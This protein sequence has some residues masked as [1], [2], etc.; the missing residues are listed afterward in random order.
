MPKLRSPHQGSFAPSA[1]RQFRRFKRQNAEAVLRFGVQ[2]MYLVQNPQSV[3]SVQRHRRL[4]FKRYL[5]LI[6]CGGVAAGR[7]NL[8]WFAWVFSAEPLHFAGCAPGILLRIH[9]LILQRQKVAARELL[10][11]EPPQSITQTAPAMKAR[12][13]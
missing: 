5:V 1:V 13:K 9:M 7:R 2:A 11:G 6:V 3:S 4:E 12:Q 10:Y 8:Q